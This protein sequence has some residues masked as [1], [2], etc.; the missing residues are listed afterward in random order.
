VRTDQIDELGDGI[1]CIGLNGDGHI[2]PTVD[3]D[4]NAVD[5]IAEPDDSITWAEASS[6]LVKLLQ[7]ITAPDERAKPE[8]A[9]IC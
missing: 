9:D 5:P 6:T 3:F 7:W 8:H 4:W 2:E 1:H